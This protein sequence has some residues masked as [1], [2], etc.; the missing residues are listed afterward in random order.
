MWNDCYLAL[1][2]LFINTINHRW[3]C[4]MENNTFGRAIFLWYES[5]WLYTH[6][7]TFISTQNTDTHFLQRSAGPRAKWH[8]STVPVHACCPLICILHMC[9]TA[10]R[11][12]E[13]IF[14]LRVSSPGA[15]K[16]GQALWLTRLCSVSIGPIPLF[17][18]CN[19][20]H[21][22][23]ISWCNLLAVMKTW[24]AL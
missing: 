22:V 15:H 19:F 12:Y 6:T 5:S 16:Q 18:I 17:Y 1:T 10:H 23:K 4:I 9:L 24:P 20:Y 7:H 3:K 8:S 21:V 14:L 11:F 13:Y 2:I